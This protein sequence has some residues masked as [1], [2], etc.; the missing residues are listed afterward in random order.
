L[1]KDHIV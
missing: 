1:M